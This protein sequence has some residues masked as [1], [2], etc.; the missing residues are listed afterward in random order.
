MGPASLPP[1]PESL[2]APL[3]EDEPPEPPLLEPVEPSSPAAASGLP[4][5]ELELLLPQAHA[6]EQ[7]VPSKA[8]ATS[9]EWFAM[10]DPPRKS[11]LEPYHEMYGNPRASPRVIAQ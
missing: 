9:L 6:S 3:P 8:H 10:A 5:E 7:D 2:P 4:F 11:Q 1:E